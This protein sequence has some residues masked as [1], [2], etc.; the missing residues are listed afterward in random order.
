[1]ISSN[2]AYSFIASQL[3]LILSSLQCLIS[4]KGVGPFSGSRAWAEPS[5]GCA[6]NK[7]YRNKW[8]EN[9][10]GMNNTKNEN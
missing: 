9:T 3:F 5:Q 8:F 7:S 2:K 10:R 1:M 6:S 4:G